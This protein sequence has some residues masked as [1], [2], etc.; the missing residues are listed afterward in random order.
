MTTVSIVMVTH[1]NVKKARQCMSSWLSFASTP[2]IAEWLVLDNGSTDGTVQFLHS[3]AAE[4]PKLK[5]IAVGTNLGCAGGRKKLFETAKSDIIFSLDSDVFLQKT[6]SVRDMVRLLEQNKT[7][8]IV[9]NHGGWVRNDWSWTQEVPRNYVGAAP[10]VTG[11][12]QMFRRAALDTISLD[13][14]YNPYWL[15]DSDFCLQ[16]LTKLKQTGYV[17]RCG[18]RHN[19]SK[20]NSGK[21]AERAEKWAYFVS[22]WKAPLGFQAC[23]PATIP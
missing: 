12:C 4:V 1:N 21:S 7:I 10:I 18:V 9:G 14:A 22:K 16:M 15:E 19:W 2:Q 6:H 3:L 20:T 17:M 23:K 13:L 8:G 5:V 11:Y